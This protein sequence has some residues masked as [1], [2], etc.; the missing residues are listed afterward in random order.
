[1]FP[2]AGKRITPRWYRILAQLAFLRFNYRHYAARHFPGWTEGD[3][4]LSQRIDT[5]VMYSV[6]MQNEQGGEPEHLQSLFD[7]FR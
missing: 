3:S 4:L 6:G 2:A 1:M 7:P 5:L